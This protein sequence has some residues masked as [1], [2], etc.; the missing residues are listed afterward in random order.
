LLRPALLVGRPRA[1]PCRNNQRRHGH[2]VA[3]VKGNIPILFNGL[4]ASVRKMLHC[5]K[6]IIALAA[7][8]SYCAQLKITGCSCIKIVHHRPYQPKRSSKGYTA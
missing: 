1:S 4:V 5:G 6:T 2:G 7:N 8:P 3:L